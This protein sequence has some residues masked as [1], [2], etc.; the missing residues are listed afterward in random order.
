MPAINAEAKVSDIALR[1]PQ[2][3]TVFSQYNLDLCC[4]GAHSLG[5]A[6]EKHKLDLDQLLRALNE[7][8]EAHTAAK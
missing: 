8:I 2:T 5:V 6:A 4:G 1:W 3:V 7:A